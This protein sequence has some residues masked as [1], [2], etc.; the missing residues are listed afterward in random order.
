MTRYRDDGY[1]PDSYGRR[2]YSSP[3]KKRSGAKE[4][5]QK[6][7][8]NQGKLAISAWNYSRG[9]GLISFS[10]FENKGS[11]YPKS[12]SG[13]KFITMVGELVNKR[14]GEVTVHPIIYCIDTGKCYLDRLDMVISTK[15]PNG[16]YFGTAR[17]RR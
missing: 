10:A 17:K 9:R 3:Q 13:K 5:I 6:K 14:T 12:Q 8:K 2:N 16:G 15:A 7:G 1:H 11:K 4:T